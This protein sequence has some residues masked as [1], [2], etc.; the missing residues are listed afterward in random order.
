MHRKSCESVERPAWQDGTL[1]LEWLGQGLGARPS[2]RAL[3][4]PPRPTLP[5]GEPLTAAAVGR[6]VGALVPEGVIFS[7]ETVSS[8]EQIWPHLN[9]RIWFPP[10]LLHFEHAGDGFA[11]ILLKLIDSFALGNN[12]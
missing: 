3:Q 4:G 11:D 12:S 8:N 9:V 5:A 7:D 1:A 2:G 6:A 10:L